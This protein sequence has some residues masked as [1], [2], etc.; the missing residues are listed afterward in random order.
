MIVSVFLLLLSLPQGFIPLPGLTL[1]GQR[2]LAIFALAVM[3]WVSEIVPAYSTSLLIIGLLIL[4]TTGSSPSFIR[5]ALPA[6]ELLSYKAILSCL[7]APVVILFLGGFF[8]AIASTKY[9]L[10]INIARVILKP[11]GTD[12]RRLQFGLMALTAFFSMFMS[13]T[14]TT[15]MMLTLLTPLLKNADRTDLSVKGMILAV[16]IAANI[17]GIGTPIGTPPNAIAFRYLTG[18]LGVSFGDWMMFAIP[19]AVVLVMF[20]WWLLGMVFRGNTKTLEIDIDSTF[21]RTPKAFLVYATIALTI[22]LWVTSSLHGINSYTVALLPV[23]VFTLSGIVNTEDLKEINWGVLWLISGGIALGY[24]LDKTGLARSLVSS[25]PLEGFSALAVL[26]VLACISSVM[27]TFM[28]NTA[29]ANLLMP[30]AATIAGTLHGLDSLGGV[31]LVVITV[32]LS[33]SMG[34]SLPISTP[35][36]ALAHA[37]GMVQSKD[38]IRAGKFVTPAG[39]VAIFGTVVA[40]GTLGYF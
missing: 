33:A 2:V 27:A 5:E 12:F 19:L 20:A 21:E 18:E 6:E 31:T 24:A 29:T 8:I 7:A 35:P 28:S 32:A 17:G 1:A 26:F 3:L 38:F 4:G 10:D 36:N 15:A 30:I 34:M 14:A 40:L 22:I 16:P 11:I 25:V 39:V 37:T 13:N 23:I 9:R